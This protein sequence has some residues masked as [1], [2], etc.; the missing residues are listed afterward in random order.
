MPVAAPTH[1]C[2]DDEQNHPGHFHLLHLHDDISVF[3]LQTGA[4]LY[5]GRNQR[6]DH[7]QTEN[8][9]GLGKD[10]Y[11]F[12]ELGDNIDTHTVSPTHTEEYG[13][14]GTQR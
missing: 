2:H 14:P 10:R 12:T 3:K 13:L 5:D 9:T 8:G 1:G 7:G 4:E 11:L 6:A